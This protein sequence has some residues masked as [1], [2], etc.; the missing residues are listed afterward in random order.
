MAATRS[1]GGGDKLQDSSDD[2]L[3]SRAS[4]DDELQA[5][6]TTS[7]KH[8]GGVVGWELVLG[9]TG[10]TLSFLLGMGLA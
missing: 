1:R 9:F 6:M 8:D 2:E 4:N 7:F 5:T 3:R 10:S